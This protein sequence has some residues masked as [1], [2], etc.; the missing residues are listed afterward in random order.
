V[1]VWAPKGTSSIGDFGAL[2]GVK[3]GLQFWNS[4]FSPLIMTKMFFFQT[5]AHFVLFCL[6]APSPLPPRAFV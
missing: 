6:G 4:Y 3:R 5:W 2:D 1:L